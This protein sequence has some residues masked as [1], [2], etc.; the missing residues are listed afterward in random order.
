[1]MKA[2]DAARP[3]PAMATWPRRALVGFWVLAFVVAG[4]GLALRWDALMSRLARLPVAA[5][6]GGSPP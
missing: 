3:A 2:A 1:M 4:V 6:T 5:E